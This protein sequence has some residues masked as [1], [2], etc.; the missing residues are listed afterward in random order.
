[1]F[2]LFSYIYIQRKLIVQIMK[3][4]NCEINEAVKYSKY[5]S[6]DFCSKKC[7]RGFA[8]KKNRKLISE[9]VSKTLKQPDITKQCEQCGTTF[10]ISVA[11]RCHSRQ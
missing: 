10:D 3:C 11:F 2:N 5:S 6:G 8:T 1:M 7:A 4:K 9:K